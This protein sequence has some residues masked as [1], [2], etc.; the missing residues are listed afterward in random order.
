MG[1]RA[2]KTARRLSCFSLG[3]F[4]FCFSQCTTSNPDYPD[5]FAC[6]PGDRMC[7][8]ATDRPVSLVCGHDATDSL[9]WVKE[10]CPIGTL[11]D[12]T[13]ATCAPAMGATPCQRQ[14][15]C[16]TGQSCVPLVQNGALSNFCVSN[17][18]AAMPAGAACSQDSDCQS[19]HCLQQQNGLYCLKAC[20]SPSNCQLPAVCQTLNVTITGVQGT[21]GSCSP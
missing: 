4:L 8:T 13:S 16:S 7:G 9:A 10:P 18:P 21:V 5:A 15:D 1:G 12:S 11:C 14:S 19:Y 6:N 17:Q 2:T 3:L 20:S